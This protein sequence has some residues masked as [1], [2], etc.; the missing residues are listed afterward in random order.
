[1]KPVSSISFPPA[2]VSI[3]VLDDRGLRIVLE[4][5]PGYGALTDDRY[6]LVWEV[7]VGFL[8]RGDPSP[9]SGPSG[10]TLNDVGTAT[11]FLKMV[12]SDGHAEP[13]YIAAMHGGSPV[14]TELRHWQISTTDAL[15]DVAA[16]YGPTSRLLSRKVR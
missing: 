11:A 16:T 1:M 13:E 10:V 14:I 6:E 8:V 15:I 4:E 3:E 12:R 5:L 2:L 9:K 7:V